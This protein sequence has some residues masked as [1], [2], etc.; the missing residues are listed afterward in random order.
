VT[1]TFRGFAGCVVGAQADDVPKTSLRPTDEIDDPNDYQD[2]DE[3]SKA[4]VHSSRLSWVQD[5]RPTE[6]DTRRCAHAD[7]PT[8]VTSSVPG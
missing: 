1:T 7:Q 2:K 8:A 5:V 4:D 6:F 3:C